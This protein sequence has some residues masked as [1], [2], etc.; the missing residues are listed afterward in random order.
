METFDWVTLGILTL[1]GVILYVGYSR[2][3]GMLRLECAASSEAPEGALPL[4]VKTPEFE[5]RYRA[6]SSLER[7]LLAI[8]LITWI[9]I[10]GRFSFLGAFSACFLYGSVAI[11]RAI[12]NMISRAHEVRTGDP[13]A[14]YGSERS[15]RLLDFMPLWAIISSMAVSFALDIFLFVV[16]K[17]YMSSA[18][19]AYCWIIVAS[20]V[21]LLALVLS[22]CLGHQSVYATAEAD[23]R[24]EEYLINE[25]VLMTLIMGAVLPPVFI[26]SVFGQIDVIPLS[27][28]PAVVLFLGAALIIGILLCI[29]SRQA[30]RRLWP[31]MGAA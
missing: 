29:G 14:R 8:G 6:R 3:N 13:G 15:L 5:Q 21:P 18:P 22:A 28:W 31:A 19:Y 7:R 30:Q 12:A 4:P 24:W 25:D 20:A 1:C 10:F 2:D 17:E 26:M 23:L 27:P 9:V 16:A 11:T